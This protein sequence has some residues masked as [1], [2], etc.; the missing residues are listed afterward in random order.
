[1]WSNNFQKHCMT[2]VH[3]KLLKH[4]FRPSISSFS[5]LHSQN[6]MLLLIID[7]RALRSL[8][9][10]QRSLRSGSSARVIRQYQWELPT[11]CTSPYLLPT[12]MGCLQHH[13]TRDFAQM[14]H[15]DLSQPLSTSLREGAASPGHPCCLPQFATE[16]ILRVFIWASANIARHIHLQ[17]P[18]FD[19]WFQQ[20]PLHTVPSWAFRWLLGGPW[21]WFE[22]PCTHSYHVWP[23][24]SAIC[25][26]PLQ[27]VNFSRDQEVWWTEAGWKTRG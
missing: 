8:R 25:S 1:M 15:S 6:L 19:L 17:P 12:L 24:P 16:S 21:T 11:L 13:L 22:Q 2:K 9:L 4:S 23:V 27:A 7:L 10:L 3:S 20:D 5:A 26:G 18:K 14:P